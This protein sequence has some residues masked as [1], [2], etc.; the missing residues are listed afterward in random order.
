MAK[1]F[2]TSTVLLTE[3]ATVP[4]GAPAA[5]TGKLF[6]ENTVPNT[7]AYVNDIGVK[8]TLGG[9]PQS[10]QLVSGFSQY[11]S[12][13]DGAQ[14]GLDL[15]AA[16]TF[17]FWFKLRRQLALSET[18][19]LM[20]KWAGAET[21]FTWFLYNN[22]GV[23]DSEI[24]ISQTASATTYDAVSL[25]GAF[26]PGVWTHFALTCD[27]SLAVG[28]EFEFYVDGVSKGN[29]SI[30]NNGPVT[31]IYPNTAPF[32]LGGFGGTGTFDGWMDDVRV[33]NVVRTA[34]QIR[35]NV[36]NE[37]VGN[38]SGLVAYWKM[39]GDAN[40]STSNANDLTLAGT[41]NPVFKSDSGVK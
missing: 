3:A 4:G 20:G 14:T 23:L 8:T 1:E 30:L 10:L 2:R 39:S 36:N 7:L 35:D 15:G 6:V 17:E 34:T 13:T 40:D 18:M 16:F 12:I 37:L 9:G 26:V 22:A 11:A 5:G 21:G 33:W 38:E 27:A 28:T 32:E 41:I 24:L 25:P 19:R 31:S 29:G